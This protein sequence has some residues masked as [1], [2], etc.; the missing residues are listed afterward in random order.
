MICVL[1]AFGLPRSWKTTTPRYTRQ[2]CL[3]WWQIPCSVYA[4]RYLPQLRA[5]VSIQSIAYLQQKPFIC[6]IWALRTLSQRIQVPKVQRSWVLKAITHDGI[7][8]DIWVLGAPRRQALQDGRFCSKRG[9]SLGYGPL[10]SCLYLGLIVRMLWFRSQC[11]F[12][13]ILGTLA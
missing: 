11:G 1:F 12:P 3:V 5:K 6:N 8:H 4:T 10:G 9:S 7:W 2:G 13:L